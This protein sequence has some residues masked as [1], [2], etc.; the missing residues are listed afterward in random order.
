M[1]DYNC[2]CVPGFVGKNCSN[3]KSDQTKSYNVHLS[4]FAKMYL[5][6]FY[7]FIY[8]GLFSVFNY[9][10]SLPEILK[11][12]VVDTKAC[13]N[14]IFYILTHPLPFLLPQPP[15][16]A[17]ISSYF[18]PCYKTLLVSLRSDDGEILRRQTWSRGLGVRS[19]SQ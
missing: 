19:P 16:P 5:Q 18:S 9:L 15:L 1:N 12:V 11:Q 2:S 17:I 14:N 4:G 7:L 8:L 10:F 3:S 6:G 13:A